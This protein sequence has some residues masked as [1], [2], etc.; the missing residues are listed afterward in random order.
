MHSRLSDLPS[1]MLELVG[2][3]TI[4]GL[5]REMEREREGRRE[6]EKGRKLKKE[7]YTSPIVY[8]QA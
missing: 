2:E 8:S 4:V 6:R 3:S 5:T 7:E 1:G